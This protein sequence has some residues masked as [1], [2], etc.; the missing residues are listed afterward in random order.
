MLIRIAHL[1][2][3][4]AYLPVIFIGKDPLA[5]KF[6]RAFS[7]VGGFILAYGLYQLFCLLSCHSFYPEYAR[8]GASYGMVRFDSGIVYDLNKVGLQVP[9]GAF[10]SSQH[11]LYIG[12]HLRD[13]YK[14]MPNFLW[15]ALFYYFLPTNKRVEGGLIE[16]CFFQS[17]FTVLGYSLTFYWLTY[18]F[19]SLRY[20]MIPFV[21]ISVVGWYSMYQ[22]LPFFE[23]TGK[24]FFGVLVFVCL[25]L[26]PQAHQIMLFRDHFLKHPSYM[27]QPYYK[28][29]FATYDW[30]DKNLPKETLV[31][32]SEDQDGY[33]MHRPF[34]SMPPGQAYNCTNLALYN[35]IYSPD[36]YL[37]FSKMS[38]KCFTSIPHAK[39]YFNKFFRILKVIKLERFPPPP[40][41]GS[42][43]FVE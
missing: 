12:Q 35:R 39:I 6:N 8:A 18:S 29:L 34:I 30:I 26:S 23:S 31:A 19:D 42:S 43:T 13:F 20:S 7:F 3:F 5:Q 38:D 14:Q 37:L 36:Y 25:F 16:L 27:E 33:F 41:A 17:I 32:S 2:N 22:A 21:L 9:L 4:L 40:L 10:F 28:D 15:P 11:F 1:Y 24:M